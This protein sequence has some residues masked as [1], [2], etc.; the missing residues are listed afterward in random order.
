M[1]RRRERQDGAQSATRTVGVTDYG[2]RVE[3]KCPTDPTHWIAKAYLPGDAP[4]PRSLTPSARGG[5]HLLF[6]GDDNNGYL[7]PRGQKAGGRRDI[8]PLRVDHGRLR[9]TCPTCA[10][11]GVREDH[12]VR[13]WRVVA[14]LV[15]MRHNKVGRLHVP[16]D[17][18]SLERATRECWTPG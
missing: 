4:E 11:G 15:A 7:G 17:A 1:S 3:L 9:W 6:D 18:R 12:Q 14:L 8:V 16:L 2:C 5:G 13:A 10:R